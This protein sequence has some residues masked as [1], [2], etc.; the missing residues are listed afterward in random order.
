MANQDEDEKLS[1]VPV[2]GSGTSGPSR[3]R[4]QPK[5]IKKE[6]GV[7]IKKEKVA[8]KPYNRLRQHAVY[9]ADVVRVIKRLNAEGLLTKEDFPNITWVAGG[10][11]RFKTN[12]QM[13]P[14][15]KAGPHGAQT[16]YAEENGEMKLV[17]P[18]ERQQEYLRSQMLSKDSAMPLTRDSGYHWVQ[19][20]TANISRR[21]FWQFLEK[22]SVLQVTRN[23]PNERKK[24]GI[25]REVRGH[26]EADLMH[27]N[28][29]LLTDI[30][31][32]IKREAKQAQTAEEVPTTKPAYFLSLVE[33]LTGYGLV[34]FCPDKTVPT[35]RKRLR[36][37]YKRMATALGAPVLSMA[38]DHGKEFSAGVLDLMTKWSPPIKQ[39]LVA[40]ASR[41][42]K[43]NSDFQRSFYRLVRLKRGGL[44]ACADQ[45]ERMTNNLLNK[46]IRL[47]PAEAVKK[48]DAEIRPAHKAGREKRKAYHIKK[49]VKIGDQCRYLVKMRKNIRTLGYKA[50]KAGHFSTR[51]FTVW[52]IDKM[53]PPRYY[54]NKAWR[55]RDEIMIVT[56]TDA[57]TDQ[58]LADRAY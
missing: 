16:L 38:T 37:L 48:T 35:I 46:Y 26:T 28:K 57:T 11:L 10:P 54:V 29:T 14:P 21:Q 18:R 51:V 30:N 34:A 49:P 6:K 7:R 12:T 17:V 50:Y 23:I 20:K 41:V 27:I 8:K 58:L 42:E 15:V 1:E 53:T 32:R 52:H 44:K 31:P 40:R 22:Q 13:V 56:G 33:Q 25:V 24:G 55:D 39:R 5:K 9:Q 43:Y 3:K 47:T 4:Q 36:V 19:A 2:T 45:A